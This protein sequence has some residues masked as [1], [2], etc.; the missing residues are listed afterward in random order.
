METAA[1][2]SN[3]PRLSGIPR[4]PRPVASNVPAKPQ[5]SEQPAKFSLTVPRSRLGAVRAKNQISKSQAEY[6]LELAGQNLPQERENIVSPLEGAP[7]EL[8]LNPAG[9]RVV[10]TDHV[11]RKDHGGDSVTESAEPD[12]E[13]SGRNPFT[14]PRRPRM[15]LSDR[16]IETLSQIPPSPS[17]RRR[18]SNFFPVEPPAS[19]LSRPASSLG[20]ARLGSNGIQYPELS[21]PRRASPTKRYNE[22]LN[23]S[24]SVKSTAGRRSVSSFTPR[25][26]PRPRTESHETNNATPSKLPPVPKLSNDSIAKWSNHHQ[27]ETIPKNGEAVDTRNPNSAIRTPSKNGT[28]HDHTSKQLFKNKT[29]APKSTK[30]RTPVSNLFPRPP[31]HLADEHKRGVTTTAK[32]VSPTL[33]ANPTPASSISSTPAK[34]PRTLRASHGPSPISR[35]SIPKDSPKSSAAL[36]ETIAK[37][38][39]ARRTMAKDQG[40]QSLAGN[41]Q[42]NVADEKNFLFGGEA[43]IKKILHKRIDTARTTGKLNISA[44]SLRDFPGEVNEMYNLEKIDSDQGEWYE[45]VD[46]VRLIAADNELESLDDWVFPDISIQA[47][48]DTDDDFGGNLFRGLES[49]DLHGNRFSRLPE[50]LRHLDRLKA[51]NLSKNRLTNGIFNLLGQVHSIRELRLGENLLDGDSTEFMSSLKSL[52][53]LDLRDNAITDISAGLADL[54]HL[55]ILNLAGNKLSSV[56]FSRLRSLPLVELDAARNQLKGT[57]IPQSVDGF[58]TLRTLDVSSNALTGLLENEA[59]ALSSLEVLNVAENRLCSIPHMSKWTE[60]RT[61]SAGGNRISVIPEGLTTL[62]KLRNIDLTRNNLK[63]LDYSIGL[64]DSLTTLRIA[65]NPLRERRHL[66]MATEELKI[67]LRNRLIPDEPAEP[68]EPASPQQDFPTSSKS[69]TKWPVTPGGILDRSSTSL[70]TVNAT[71]L[72]PILETNNIKSLLL[73]HNALTSIP[74]AIALAQATLT[75]LDLGYNRL[76]ISSS[77]FPSALALPQLTTLSLA[78][79]ALPSLLPLLNSLT[80]PRL[81]T[82]DISHNRLT[83]LLPPLRHAFPLLTTVLAS[84][85]AIDDLPIDAVRGLRT[86]DVSANEISHLRP[87]LGLLGSS[88]SPDEEEERGGTLQELRV[89][90]NR[91]RVPRREVLERGS[92]A[93]LAWLRGKV[94][95]EVD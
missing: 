45:S 3:L 12:A 28:V 86:L 77:Y 37:A 19:S 41:V 44:L 1:G 52:E 15:S 39:A 58:P 46:L 35:T 13:N 70:E 2:N 69:C 25:S 56:P 7:Q 90:G 94:V 89:G 91:F 55:R 63:A 81:V 38:K 76:S 68:F 80:A 67:E 62:E 23:V 9:G 42:S 71:D 17:P 8:P 43:E 18:K 33:P 4:L 93:L 65:N 24:Q 20:Q 22:P 79:N 92:A 26:V 27:V 51:V 21:T 47:A 34:P 61:L 85:N 54:V 57:L 95:S 73:H 64:M 6:E 50:G 66:T 53:V 72:E 74:S 84:E 32:R 48:S 40:S 30:Q 11:R 60:L 10:A 49:L 83:S 31:P 14:V 16:T 75:T 88:S 5:S 87:E 82:L 78:S 29:Y 59:T 36:R